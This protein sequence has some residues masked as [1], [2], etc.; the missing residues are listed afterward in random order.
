MHRQSGKHV[1]TH[2][3]THTHLDF[4]SNRCDFSEHMHTQIR[5][6]TYRHRFACVADVAAV[7]YRIACLCATYA[8]GKTRVSACMLP[9]HMAYT[10]G[11]HVRRGKSARVHLSDAMLSPGRQRLRISNQLHARG[12]HTHIEHWDRRVLRLPA[13]SPLDLRAAQTDV[14]YVHIIFSECART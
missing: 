3:R 11:V 12:T 8:T 2:T 5:A 14:L 4:H 13:A 9:M 1:R 6:H 10:F 7:A